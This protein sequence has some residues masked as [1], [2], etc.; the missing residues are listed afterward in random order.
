M[1]SARNLK[2]IFRRIREAG[3]PPKFTQDFLRSS[4]GF[5]SSTDRPVIGVLKALGFISSDG[6]PTARYNSYRDAGRSGQ[7]L[8]QGLREGWSELFLADENA[9]TKSSAQLTELFKSVSGKGEAVG[10]KM[11]TTFKNLVELAD[12]STPMAQPI[13][14]TLVEPTTSEESQEP[15]AAP[16]AAAVGLSLHHDVH[17]HLPS[18]SDVSVYVAIFRALKGEL[19]D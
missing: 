15:P 7:T 6:V 12:W 1:T 9:N 14:P 13:A 5:P 18:T 3:T 17:I 4:L 10:Q 8:A 19:L 16:R 2:D 11:A